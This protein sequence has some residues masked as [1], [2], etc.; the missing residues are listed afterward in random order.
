MAAN[1]VTCPYCKSQAFRYHDSDTEMF[2]CH[3]CQRNTTWDKAEKYGIRRNG[4][5]SSDS[6]IIIKPTIRGISLIPRCTVLTDLE[7]EHRC[8]DFVRSRGIPSDFY[9]DL[10]Y[11]ESFG[12]LVSPFGY[13]FKDGPPKLI[14][15]FRD[16]DG[17]IFGLQ[18][19]A[20]DDSMP[21]YVTCMFRD[22]ADK[23]FGLDRWNKEKTT[24]VTEGPID[25]FFLKNSLA[26]AGSDLAQNKY[27]EPNKDITICLDNEPRNA[28]I[29]SKYEKFIKN[30][31]SI[32]VWPDYVKEKDINDMV[33]AGYNPQEIIESNTFSGLSAKIKLNNWKKV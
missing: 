27:L 22:D 13:E 6:S 4:G 26:M 11:T 20:L 9:H 7:S 30:G 17:E 24:I 5:R 21:K 31:N 1:D 8:I 3:D 10:F 14:I 23:I 32:V 18:A 28:V 2:L 33:L 19:R 12:S 16:R 25:S 29:V 15:P